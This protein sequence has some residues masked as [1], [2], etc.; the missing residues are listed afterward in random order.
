LVFRLVGWFS[1]V[2]P[3]LLPWTPH[4]ELRADLCHEC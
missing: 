1:C 4:W 3:Y 2:L